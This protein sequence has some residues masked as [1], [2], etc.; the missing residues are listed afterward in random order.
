MR[1]VLEEVLALLPPFAVDF[2]AVE[3]E[4]MI[5]RVF[6]SVPATWE[7]K[8]HLFRNGSPGSPPRASGMTDLGSLDI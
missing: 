4:G 6:V 2:D 3:V 5:A 7:E 8:G 1:V